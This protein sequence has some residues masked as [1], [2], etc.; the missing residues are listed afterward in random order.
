MYEVVQSF[1]NKPIN[2]DYLTGSMAM[3]PSA[4][5]SFTLIEIDAELMIPI[6]FKV[7]V[8]DLEKSNAQKEGVF[9]LQND[10]LETYDLEDVSPSSMFALSE[11][12][13]NDKEVAVKYL[14]N[15]YREYGEAPECDEI[16]QRTWYC[17]TT[18][19]E[20]LEYQ[21]CVKTMPDILG[22]AFFNIIMNV[23]VSPWVR[24][25]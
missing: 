19:I 7:Y 12:I 20:V 8:M 21:E 13:L 16:C 2:L 14:W 24:Q 1:D 10:H 11:K 18:A 25:D 3:Q 5:P 9:R 17:D 22:G 4:E 15:Q 23:L 6:N